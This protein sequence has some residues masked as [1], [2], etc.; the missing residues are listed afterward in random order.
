M[1]NKYH[2]LVFEQNDF[3][4]NQVVEELLRERSTYYIDKNK[5]LDFWILTNPE[6]INNKI[7]LEKIK[8]TNYYKNL[9]I[10]SDVFFNV[11]ISTDLEFIKWIKL[12][13]GYFEEIS[14]LLESKKYTSNGV[15]LDYN[16]LNTYNLTVELKHNKYSLSPNIL[17][18][19]FQS[20]TVS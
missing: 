1:G 16:F 10:N 5:L 4:K 19:Q 2:C 7:I 17:V 3:F 8:L 11:L 15:Y 18:E 12:R 9:K 6:F 14:N 13:L 20:I